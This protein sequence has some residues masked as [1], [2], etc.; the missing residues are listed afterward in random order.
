VTRGTVVGLVV[1]VAGCLL[2]A[3]YQHQAMTHPA[4]RPASSGEAVTTPV[5]AT[6]V[7]ATPVGISIPA[8]G[9]DAPVVA[10]GLRPDGAM[11]VPGVR[12][13]GWYRLGPR[14]G[15]PGPAVIVGH[16][17]SRRGPAVFYRL[18]R[19]RPGARIVVRRAGGAASVFTVETVE[20]Q[21]KA[22]LPVGRIWTRTG[23]P[24]LRLITCGGSF[25]RASGHYRDNVIVYARLSRP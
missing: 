10:V 13:A 15:D 21:P 11:E 25:D 14:P 2:A 24:V 19:L 16:V 23:Q 3:G 4:E 5:G 17:D 8:I 1:L 22:A 7:G 18:R 20:R 6:P 12:L 9:V